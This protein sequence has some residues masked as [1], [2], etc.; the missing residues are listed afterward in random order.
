MATLTYSAMHEQEDMIHLL[1]AP[2]CPF[3]KIL[4]QQIVLKVC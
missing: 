1:A 4:L 3:L 2:K